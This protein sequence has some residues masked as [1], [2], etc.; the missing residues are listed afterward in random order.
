MDQDVDSEQTHLAFGRE[1]LRRGRRL[2]QVGFLG[3]GLLLSYYAVTANVR[4]PFHLTQGLLILFL[5][6][7]PGLFWA[8]RGAEDLPTFEVLLLTCANTYAF[9]LLNG[10]VQLQHYDTDTITT[11]A[12][13]VLLYQLLAITTHQLVSGRP[14]VS[15]RF[16]DDILTQS[17]QRYI[18]YGL[19]L[20]AAYAFL[21]T[22]YGDLVAYDIHSVL[23]AIFTG[24]GLVATFAQARR[25]GQG[26]L[27]PREQTFF[28]L[29]VSALVVIHFSTLFLVAGLSVVL[30]ALVGYVSGARRL[31]II[32]TLVFFT[33]TAILHNGKSVMRSQYW[34]D[35]GTRVQ[36]QV[37]ALPSFFAAWI[38]AGLTLTGHDAEREMTKK[39]FDR[40]SLF[41]ILCLVADNTPAR[42][43]YLSGETYRHIPSQFIPRFFWKE[44]PQA[45]ISTSTLSIYY[46]LQTE[47]TVKNT[48]IGFGM[49]AESYANFG[50]IG[51]GLLAVALG[52]FYK[53]VQSTTAGCRL[54]S[55]PGLF[56]IILMA[57]SFQTEATMAIWLSSMFQA[58]VAVLGIPFVVRNLF[59]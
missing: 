2:F 33:L 11:A 24:I 16:N 25:W 9:P 52:A 27:P 58:C 35:D 42:L 28:L 45:H 12:N 40:T 57:W 20:S 22:Y 23:R 36:V 55:Y 21:S 7:L 50:F 47:E 13:L 59:R 1:R 4:E 10:H 39:L 8:R 26:R 46:G 19:L 6:A 31:P 18:G 34:K 32:A 51:V 14:S 5:A 17:L 49:V 30:L 3:V 38:E 53:F 43:P 48:T 54:L 56:L 37:E 29:C 41:H 44:K 15:R